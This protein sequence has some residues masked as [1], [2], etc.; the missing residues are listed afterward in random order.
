MSQTRANDAYA[1]TQSVNINRAYTTNGLNQYTDIGSGL[2]IPTYDTK[3]NLTSAGTT[4]YGYNGD[5]L[6]TSTG[7][8]IT[9]TID[10]DPLDR[11]YQTTNGASIRRY[12]FDGSVLVGEYNSSNV[13]VDR[14]VHGPGVDEPLVWYY[15]GTARRWLHADERGSVT[16]ISGDSGGMLNINSYDEYGIPQSTNVGRFQYT[17][18][19]YLSS[20]GLY[21]YKARMYSATLGRFL[22]T[23]PVGYDDGMNIYAYVG[24]DPING[25]DPSGNDADYVYWARKLLAN[26]EGGGGFGGGGGGWT[27][28]LFGGPT[29]PSYA[30][31][32]ALRGTGPSSIPSVSRSFT[33]YSLGVSVNLVL[34]TGKVGS[35]GV[36]YDT[37]SGA[38]G[39]YSSVASAVGFDL[40]AGISLGRSAGES[41]LSGSFSGWSA[42]YLAS[43]GQS[44]DSNGGL[45]GE[46][47]GVGTGPVPFSAISVIGTGGF[48]RAGIYTPTAPSIS[49]SRFNYISGRTESFLAPAGRWVAKSTPCLICR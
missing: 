47:I 34:G 37:A 36:Y 6:L 11:L 33:T 38:F 30:Y 29:T 22:Q 9:S 17:G 23:D 41:S 1:W 15:S 21:Y 12:V 25:T 16:A 45:T 24:N 3:G 31:N 32:G 46:S 7:G 27:G 26:D 14:F 20:L 48:A 10:Y 18:Q 19:A 43:Y 39:G 35:L 28:T 49:M 2:I 4:T 42:G 40:S 13:L 8:A 5:N 44:Y